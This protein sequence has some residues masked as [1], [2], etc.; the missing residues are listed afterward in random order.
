M[1][2]GY[3]QTSVKEIRRILQEEFNIGDEDLQKPK[4]ELVHLLLKLQKKEEDVTEVEKVEQEQEVVNTDVF[5]NA[6]EQD[7]IGTADIE[8]STEQIQPAAGSTSWQ[9]HV[10][11]LFREDELQDGHPVHHGLVRV[12]EELIG[13]ILQRNVKQ[14]D[15]ANNHNSNTT[16]IVVELVVHVTNPDL[17]VYNEKMV[18]SDVA[19]AN[20]ANTDE[21]YSYYLTAMA[22]TR[23]ESRVLRRMLRLKTAAADELS[24]TAK[25]LM[26]ADDTDDNENISEQQITVLDHLCKR[27][28]ID[29]VK[30]LNSGSKQYENVKG[31]LRDTAA[32]M[33]KAL[34]DLQ[35]NPDKIAGEI[36]GYKKNWEKN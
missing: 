32:K 33:I 23:A 17:P 7:E 15:P 2:H 25:T 26:F 34:N 35:N 36:K 12:T 3:E 30:F 4:L 19:D 8:V 16:S 24:Q 27:L 10:M 20:R 21:P 11:S 1:K 18:Y 31:V 13:P 22:M 5:D 28:D 9:D 29:T 14:L 6:E